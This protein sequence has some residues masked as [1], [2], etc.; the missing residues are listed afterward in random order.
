MVLNIVMHLIQLLVLLFVDFL[1]HD[2]TIFSIYQLWFQVFNLIIQFLLF[3]LV[4][5]NL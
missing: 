3:N 2:Q 1:S 5:L 4:F